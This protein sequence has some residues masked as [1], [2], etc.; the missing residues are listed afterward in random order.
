[1]VLIK[2]TTVVMKN[3]L[4]SSG[5]DDHNGYEDDYRDHDDD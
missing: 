3:I 4:I 2:V 1:M 5:Y